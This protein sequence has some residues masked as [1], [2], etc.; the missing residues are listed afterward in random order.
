MNLQTLEQTL[1]QLNQENELKK[2]QV[3]QEYCNANNPYKVGDKFTDHVG[4][5]IV[6]S[7]RYSYGSNPCCVYF[8]IELKKDGTPRK[9]N[10][11]R[12]AWQSND[13]SV[14]N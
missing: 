14:V 1:T 12:Q 10:N 2:K 11:K 5:I 4:T 8:G 9:D 3:M 6:E 7:I 13:V